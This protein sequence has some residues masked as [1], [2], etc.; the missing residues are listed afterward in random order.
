MPLFSRFI[1]SLDLGY[2]PKQNSSSYLPPSSNIG[3]I[4]IDRFTLLSHKTGGSQRGSIYIDQE[5]GKFLI[6]TSLS[7]HGVMNEF[8][9]SFII[10]KIM[11]NKAPIN[12][13][14]RLEDGRLGIAS[15][16]IPN[17]ITLYDYFIKR[18]KQ[19]LKYA[20]LFD[21][22][23]YILFGEGIRKDSNLD[24]K[25]A[26]D[27]PEMVEVHLLATFIGHRDFHSTNK[28]FIVKDNHVI[29]AAL[30]DFD[31]S[32]V[33]ASYALI[34]WTPYQTGIE[35]ALSIL[36][37]IKTFNLNDLYELYNLFSNIGQ[38][39]YLQQVQ[40]YMVKQLQKIDMQIEMCEL[41][42]KLRDDTITDE[43]YARLITTNF[44]LQQ[45]TMQDHT[46]FVIDRMIVKNDI[47]ALARLLNQNN[48]FISTVAKHPVAMTHHIIEQILPLLH[49]E[50]KIMLFATLIVNSNNL[51]DL[52][53]IAILMQENES[54]TKICDVINKIS[55]NKCHN[56][57]NLFTL[58]LSEA[59]NDDRS[60]IIKQREQ[61]ALNKIKYIAITEDMMPQ[62]ISINLDNWKHQSIFKA[63]ACI[64]TED[65]VHYNDNIIKI[66]N[67][68]PEDAQQKGLILLANTI[69]A[70]KSFDAAKTV[71]EKITLA[72]LEFAMNMIF[73]GIH[74][75]LQHQEYQQNVCSF[76]KMQFTKLDPSS[77]YDNITI[78]Y[79]FGWHTLHCNQFLV[80]DFTESP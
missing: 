36:K 47:N 68:L 63:L 7:M 6:K 58:E 12:H 10:N 74:Y 39:D 78:E 23:K 60:Y 21:Q 37:Q 66:T 77:S 20:S 55:N 51:Q 42:I 28:G 15:T 17:F 22:Q 44:E 67:I 16:L 30:I 11:A 38:L 4:S 13:I 19:E 46:N 53:K 18:A 48:I 9:S 2:C 14:V 25:T 3:I 72:N 73:D 5:G 32:L 54:C 52:K 64:L 26:F 57:Y 24:Y 41:A 79:D 49:N 76:F 80:E 33:K 34:E 62:P 59:N 35:H 71:L 40:Q 75:Q 70:E 56:N 69:V 31:N 45:L 65:E 29:G 8:L 27:F 43:E 61:N 50:V 1:T